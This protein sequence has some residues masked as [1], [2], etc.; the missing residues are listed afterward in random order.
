MELAGWLLRCVAAKASAVRSPESSSAAASAKRGN[1]GVRRFLQSVLVL[2]AALAV[3]TPLLKSQIGG[4]GY[5]IVA[6]L[7]AKCFVGQTAFLTTVTA[8]TNWYGCTSANTWT[9]QTSGGAGTGTVTSVS[10]VTTS[11]AA[12]FTA[13]VANSTSTPQITF[14]LASGAANLAW[15]TPNGS[16]GV[17]SYRAIVNADLPASGATAGTYTS[18]N[19]T[20][21]TQGIIT[22]AASGTGGGGNPG[23]SLYST[24]TY[25]SSTSFAGTG[26]G[27]TGQIYLAQGAGGPALFETMSNDATITNLGVITVTSSNGTAFGNQAFHNAPTNNFGFAYVSGTGTFGDT[28]AC[29][30]GFPPIGQGAGVAPV[31]GPFGL[32]GGGAA[33]LLTL[34]TS[35]QNWATIG[36]GIVKVTTTTGAISDATSSDIAAIL[37][38]N[39][40]LNN[41]ANT[42]TTGLQSLAAADLLSPTHTSDPGTCTAGQFEFNSTSA[43]FK[44]CTATNTWTAFSAGAAV[45]WQ[46]A[47]STIVSSSTLNVTTGTGITPALTSVGGVATLSMSLNTT[48]APSWTLLQS[49]Q[50]TY[51]ASTNGT[52]GYTGNTNPALTA[53]TAGND[54]LFS[55]DVASG[56]SPSVNIGGVGILTL[57]QIDGATAPIS[58]QIAASAY[59]M[60]IYDGTHMR[61]AQ[62]LPVM[63]GTTTTFMN[64]VGAFTVPF[65]LT[66]TGSSGAATF[67][68]G[69]LNVP[70][71]TAGTPTFPVTVAG[72]V[73]SG[74]VPYFSSTTVESSSGLLVANGVMVGGG[75]GGA[76]STLAIVNNAVLVTNG[77]GIPSESTTLPNNLAMQT[78]ASLTLTNA[79]GLPLTTGVTGILP[80]ANGG[81]AA[82]LTATNGGAVYSTAS[83]FAITAGPASTNTVLMG[84]N[85]GAP[86]FSTATYPVTVTIN[87]LLYASAANVVSTLATA[88]SSVLTTSSGGV[89]SWTTTLPSGVAAFTLTTTGTS[90]AATY[91][92]GTLNI[93]QYSGGSSITWTTISG[94]S[95]SGA[96]ASGYYANNAALVSI[97]LPSSCTV[98]DPFIIDGQG[99][100]GWKITQ[101][102]GQTIHFGT[103]S[104]TT[105]TAGY[106]SDYNGSVVDGQYD[107]VTLSCMVANT[108]W[109]VQ[110]SVGNLWVN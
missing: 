83:A 21:N 49:G 16:S 28:V 63:S 48:Y 89:P 105:G 75:A 98:G 87:R 109:S 32:A 93:P 92:S 103:K 56:S 76:P 22:S 84:T 110:A 12:L 52:N 43:A 42:Y 18:A 94:T 95:Q 107:S 38:A 5:I 2:L 62:F 41:Q 50:G 23:G 106:L 79:T 45:A 91:S 8:G 53:Y 31:C 36:T 19:I 46:L 15:M 30:T 97:T 40:V 47:G 17:G 64:G 96:T 68:G 6:S 13:A 55:N 70:Q 72:T 24:Q 14:T 108:D 1:P 80:L 86:F 37:P 10:T 35:S 102:A 61:I 51:V 104:S 60:L 74:G 66:T 71:Y 57:Y 54:F 85:A 82:N 73:T 29:T 65:T 20:V 100:G 9:V 81:T 69:T 33:V 58:N 25:A 59:S 90:G 39:V 7:P 77:S 78:P 11:P 26:P 44:G 88:N 4:Q 3:T 34:G 67:S 101:A 27:T 99:A